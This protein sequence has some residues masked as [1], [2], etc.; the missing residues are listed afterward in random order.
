MSMPVLMRQNK[1]Y[2]FGAL[3]TIRDNV[4]KTS[5]GDNI[6]QADENLNLKHLIEMI[7]LLNIVPVLKC[8]IQ[9]FKLNKHKNRI[10]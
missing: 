2:Y 1:T 8:S 5:R 10:I 7:L 9:Q 3:I 6:T 4:H